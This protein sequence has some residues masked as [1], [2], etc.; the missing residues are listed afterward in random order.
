[1]HGIQQGPNLSRDDSLAE[2]EDSF[3]EQIEAGNVPEIMPDHGSRA[4]PSLFRDDS[5]GQL[6]ASFHNQVWC[7]CSA[8]LV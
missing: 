3:R 5:L 6:K 2:L 1:M 8:V 7:W 4:M